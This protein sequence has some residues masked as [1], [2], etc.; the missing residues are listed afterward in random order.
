MTDDVAHDPAETPAATGPSED[1]PKRSRRRGKRSRNKPAEGQVA[2]TQTAP[3]SGE[4]AAGETAR[5]AQ[6]RGGRKSGTKKGGY[7]PYDDGLDRFV[8]LECFRLFPL[9]YPVQHRR[10]TATVSLREVDRRDGEL[11]LCNGLHDGPCLWPDG[12][13]VESRQMPPAPESSVRTGVD[14][15]NDATDQ[16]AHEQGLSAEL[17][18]E[19]F[20]ESADHSVMQLSESP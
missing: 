6:P 8:C 11:L 13:M 15:Q 4:K 2:S 10:G 3:E 19:S 1:R 18:E 14:R 17:P 7:V 9:T 12:V 5:P 16:D 20:P